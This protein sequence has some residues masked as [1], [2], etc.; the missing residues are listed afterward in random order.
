VRSPGD[1]AGS[2]RFEIRNSRSQ[3]RAGG[4]AGEMGEFE[5]GG[6]R[7][8]RQ[9]LGGGLVAVANVLEL[10]QEFFARLARLLGAAGF[11]S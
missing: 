7:F 10:L 1:F 11:V 2:D 4:R 3:N 6:F 5:I 8:K 9:S